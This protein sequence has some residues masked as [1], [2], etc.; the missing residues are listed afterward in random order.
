M[1]MINNKCVR[2]LVAQTL[3]NVLNHLKVKKV[4]IAKLIAKF[5]LA[6]A[7]VMQAD[8]MP[9]SRRHRRKGRLKVSSSSNVDS[10]RLLSL[11]STSLERTNAS[12]LTPDI[13]SGQYVPNL[14]A[15]PFQV[16]REYTQKMHNQ[17]SSPTLGKLI[18]DWD[19]EEWGLLTNAR[20]P[21]L[22]VRLAVK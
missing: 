16:T 17:T 18:N 14:I 13:L 4:D 21:G 19:Q 15:E 2:N 6:K 9:A 5:S 1:S 20:R 8:I 7:K 10:L 12:Q 11:V 3:T 22:A